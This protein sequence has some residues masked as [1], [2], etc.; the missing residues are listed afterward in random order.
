MKIKKETYSWFIVK[1]MDLLALGGLLRFISSDTFL[2]ISTMRGLRYALA[3]E[4]Q[5]TL[6]SLDY[7]SEETSYPM[8]VLNWVKN[9]PANHISIKGDSV[10]VLD[11]NRTKNLSWGLTRDFIR[12]FRGPVLGDVIIAT[13]G[14][15]TG[16]N[17]LFLRR[18][19]DDTLI[20]QYDFTFA[21]VPITLDPS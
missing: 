4:G 14:M 17:T 21:D 11:I 3:I 2:T 1:S 6:W 19:R 10:S 5:P 18:I 15:T 13:S 9:G 7:F 12:Y 8:V 16:N 20:E